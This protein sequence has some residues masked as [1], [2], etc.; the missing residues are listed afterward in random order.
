MYRLFCASYEDVGALLS[1]AFAVVVVV[2]YDGEGK[3]SIRGRV[4]ETNERTKHRLLREAALTRRCSPETGRPCTPDSDGTAD[5]FDSTLGVYSS[6][7]YS[8]RYKHNPEYTSIKTRTTR[9][10][11]PIH[12]Y[13]T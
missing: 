10:E 4:R 9:R 5:N 2:R 12:R 7:R 6:Q 11:T 13:K 3:K 8:G 1:V